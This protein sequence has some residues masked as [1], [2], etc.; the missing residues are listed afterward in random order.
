MLLAV[1]NAST[2]MPADAAV[3]AVEACA[4]QIWLHVAPQ[5]DMLPAT[6]LYC[7]HEQSVPAEAFRLTILDQADEPRVAGYHR[8]TPEGLPYARV[9]VGR[10]LNHA[11]ELL[12]GMLSV[13]SVISHEI[14]EWFVD[15]Y[16]NL[17]ADG[18]QGEYAVEIC[19]PVA[20]DIYEID[21]VTVSNFVTRHFFNP[22]PRPGVRLDHL[23]KLHAPFSST[24]GGR[25]QV[26]RNGKVEAILGAFAIGDR[27]PH[28]RR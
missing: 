23:G 19:D 12:T 25:M 24:L 7:E 2:L 5:W 11:G 21:G 22:R 9:F 6:V 13:S 4:K 17:W 18:P 16:L 20:E 28:D 15:P 3:R 26:R 8:V 10:I 27:R 1:L 14:C